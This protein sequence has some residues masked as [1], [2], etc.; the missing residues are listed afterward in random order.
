VRTGD[1]G[2]QRVQESAAAARSPE[3]AKALTKPATEG[4]DD[5]HRQSPPSQD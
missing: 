4:D 3:L 5:P 1:V 2:E